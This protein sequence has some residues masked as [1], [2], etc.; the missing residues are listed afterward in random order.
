M[1]EDV[2]IDSLE[3]SDSELIEVLKNHG[4]DRRGL[5]KVLGTGAGVAA[6][7]GTAAGSGGRDARIDEVFGAAYS[8]DESPPP[9]LV[10]HV[11]ELHA[12]R[13][14]DPSDG[15][16]D[17]A[18]FP[19]LPD[20]PDPDD[21]PDEFHTEFFFDPVGLHVEPGNVVNF[22]THNH[23]HTVTSFHPKYL[24]LPPNVPGTINRVP[25]GAFTSPPYVGDESWLYKFTTEGVYDILC[26]PHIGFGMVMRIVVSESDDVSGFDDYGDLPLSGSVEQPL[27]NANLVLTDE[28]LDPQNI[29][30]EGSIAWENLTPHTS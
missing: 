27:Y 8:V 24:P 22:A 23:E 2:N 11:V 6:L 3:L 4:I 29:V 10:D 17:L 30:D 7:S 18:D 13:D 19:L 20:G 15:L 5:M 9:G 28:M 12:H 26:L 1:S 14:T 16:G 21:E 25:E